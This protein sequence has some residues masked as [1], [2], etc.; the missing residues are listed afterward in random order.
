MVNYWADHS[1]DVE[2]G[3]TA[4]ILQFASPDNED[5]LAG[6]VCLMM[7]FAETGPFRGYVNK[8]MVS[9]RHR[10]K[11]VARQV[12]ECLEAVAREKERFL[13]MLDTTVG[14]PAEKVY[15]RLGY[16]S[17]GVAPKYGISPKDGSLVDERMFYK[18]L[19]DEK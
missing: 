5:E 11:G 4:I 6:Y 12:M 13:L 8:L 3:H 7:P 2:K 15:P 19:R 14:L 9:P 1:A 16:T 18:D 17:Y 10:R